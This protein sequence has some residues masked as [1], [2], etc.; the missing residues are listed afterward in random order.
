[1]DL[2]GRQLY[3]VV[4]LFYRELQ[5]FLR[6]L[7]RCCHFSFYILPKFALGLLRVFGLIAGIGHGVI[8]YV[9][10]L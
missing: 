6:R 3:A 10:M 4:H 9:P 7:D 5:T 8:P 1:M 2:A